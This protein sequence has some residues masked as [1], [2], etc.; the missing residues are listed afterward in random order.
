MF[1]TPHFWHAFS[2]HLDD[3]NAVA[4]VQLLAVLYGGKQLDFVELQSKTTLDAVPDDPRWKF[5]INFQDSLHSIN[6]QRA[7][8]YQHGT[9]NIKV[10]VVDD[11]IQY[12]H[13]DLG[14]GIGPTKRVVNGR[15]Y[16]AGHPAT[17][18]I[19]PPSNGGVHGTPVAGSIGAMVNNNRNVAGAAGGWDTTEGVSLYSMKC[20][21]LGDTAGLSTDLERDL[22]GA[23]VETAALTTAGSGF[24]VHVITNSNGSPYY[25]EMRRRALDYAYRLCV[26]SVSSKGN[27][28]SL[29]FRSPADFDYNKIIAVGAMGVELEENGDRYVPV[30]WRISNSA[31]SNWGFGLD[32]MAPG[33]DV[34]VS[35]QAIATNQTLRDTT[36]GQGQVR[37]FAATSAATPQVSAIAGLILS[38]YNPDNSSS[39]PNID[40]PLAP[41]DVE[42][43]IS[44]SALDMN[45]RAAGKPKDTTGYD[46]ITGYGLVKADSALEAM[47]NPYE[48][49]HYTTVGG[50]IVDTM[51]FYNIVIVAPTHGTSLIK[52][53]SPTRIIAGDRYRVRKTIA[54]H[55][56]DTARSWGRGG[57]G[58]VGWSGSQPIDA[59]GNAS[60]ELQT[61]YCRVIGDD[62]PNTG[63]VRDIS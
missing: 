38:E 24:G 44:I 25:Q 5:Q 57:H 27:N 56:W 36:E 35:G 7:W 19:S 21:G 51:N 30:R 39:H 8:D 31:G 12:T 2:V 14:G 16:Y 6:M 43:L 37:S 41:E 13:P 62:A 53:S 49:R 3:T 47:M 26:V 4:A 17:D 54:L 48:L 61:G 11:G 42:G 22:V 52:P 23:W 40:R 28:N 63:N 55:G 10:A 33:C 50:T 29:E 18:S 45:F 59:Q 60:R 46:A 32:V 9:R 15:E 34:V 20:T 1:P 58:T